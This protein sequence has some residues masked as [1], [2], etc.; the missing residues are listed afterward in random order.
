VE[1][2]IVAAFV[3]LIISH[4]LNLPLV[5]RFRW[6]ASAVHELKKFG[7]WIFVST[8]VTFFAGSLDR[9]ILGRLLTLKELGLYS[10]ALNLARFP[11][12]INSRLTSTVLFPVL[13]RSQDDPVTLVKQSLRARGLI[14]LGGGAA[15]ISF[16]VLSPPFFKHFYDHRYAAAGDI[17]QWLAI[18]IWVSIILTSMDRVPLALGHPKAIFI[19]NLLTTAGYGVAVLGYYW[20]G[21]PG[22]ILGLCSGF[23]AAHLVMLAWIPTQRMQMFTQSILYTLCVAI[24]GSGAVFWMHWISSHAEPRWEITSAILTAIAPCAVAGTLVILQLRKTMKS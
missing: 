23:I 19:C 16:A 22:F 17:S 18:M 6:D 4:W 1:G 3:H 14:L 10:I 15:V 9:I 2:G 13:A 5:N 21:L 8:I 24:Y 20:K 12:E 7:S 11:I